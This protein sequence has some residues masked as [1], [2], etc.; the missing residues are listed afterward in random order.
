LRGRLCYG[1]SVKS[2]ALCLVCLLLGG[3]TSPAQTDPALREQGVF[4]LEG[5]VP[6]KVTTVI[7]TPTTLYLRRDFQMALA[8]LYPGQTAEV[9]GNSPEG[10]LIKG[11]ARNNTVVGWIH[12]Q[13]LP[14]GFDTGIFVAAKKVEEHRAAIAVAIANKSVV[15]G[16]TPN[17]VEQAVGHPTQTSSRTDAHG[18]SMTWIFTTY[19]E[20]PQYTYAFDPFGRPVLQ[21]YYVKI[22]IGQLIVGFDKGLVASVEENKTDPNSPGVVTN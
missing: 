6:D 17:E 21:T 19:R 8:V 20:E 13:D 1:Q 18:S 11:T 7:R 2:L 15:Q 10:Y 16:M 14:T 5:N 3:A 9:I 22:P 12:P 4:Y